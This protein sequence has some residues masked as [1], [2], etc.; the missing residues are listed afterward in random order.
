MLAPVFI[1]KVRIPLLAIEDSFVF[2]WV[3]VEVRCILRA[4][5]KARQ[6]KAR[7]GKARQ[8]KARQGKA[9]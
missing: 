9:R 6:G 1:L 4:E 5:R 2:F 7:Q 8:G 3:L